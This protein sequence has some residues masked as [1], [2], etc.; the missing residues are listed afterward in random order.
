MN[1]TVIKTII[2]G[3]A[4]SAAYEFIVRPQIQKLKS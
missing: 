4:V 1:K 3:L 2:I